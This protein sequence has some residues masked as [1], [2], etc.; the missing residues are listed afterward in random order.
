M[1]RKVATLKYKGA[2]IATV[3]VERFEVRRADGRKWKSFATLAAAKAYID[4]F[5]KAVDMYSAKEA[6]K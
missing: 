1:S 3:Y 4:G 2:V 6:G 5:S